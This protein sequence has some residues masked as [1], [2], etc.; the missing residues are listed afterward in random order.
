LD[1][2]PDTSESIPTPDRRLLSLDAL[3]GFDMFWIIGG[4]HIAHAAAKLTGWA[5]LVWLSGQLS[6]PKWHGFAFY[7]LIFPLFLFMA[8]VA[9]PFSFEKRLACGETRGQLYRHVVLRGLLLVLLGMIFNGLLKFDWA[10]MRYPSVL[11]R[12]GLAYL[13]AGLIVLNTGLRGRLVW[14]VALLAA[15]WAALRFIPVPGFGAHDL[16]PGHTLTDYIDRQL[17]PGRL[18]Q[19]DRDPEGLLATVPA[20][21]TALLGAVTGTLLKSEKLGGYRKTLIMIV[22]GGVF[23]GLAYLWDFEFPINKNLWTSSFVLHCAGWSLVFLALFYLVI[24]VWRLRI[25]AFPLIVIGSNAIFIYMAR[26]CI[27]FQH[28]SDFFFGGALK[29]AGRYEP[30]LAATCIVLVEWLLLLFLY[31]KRVFLK[32]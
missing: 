1:I 8:G 4:E 23:L 5:W 27:D 28:T 31:K 11:G 10:T 26:R 14:I 6:H 19:G 15:Y 9:M 16:E 29:H 2:P 24:D 22:A 20:I 3:R 7:D 25:W 21:A 32:V 17:I 18:Y 12:I 30:L 13:F